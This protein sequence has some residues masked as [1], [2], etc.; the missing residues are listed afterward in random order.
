[1][2]VDFAGACTPDAVFDPSAMSTDVGKL[3]NGSSS[4]LSAP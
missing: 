3:W 1:M 2:S 4:M